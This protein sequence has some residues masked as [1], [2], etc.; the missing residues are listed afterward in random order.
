MTLLLASV[1]P[2]VIF[3]YVIYQKDHEKEPWS[4]LLKCLAGGCFS[5]ILSLAFSLPLSSLSGLFP[6][7]LLGSFQLSFL[8]AAIPEEVAKFIIL[9]GLVWKSR[10]LN[11]HYDGI[12]YAVF[13]SLGF[14]LIENILYVYQGGMQVALVRAVL[15][16]PGHGLFAVLMGYYFTLARFHEGGKRK[17]FLFKSLSLP[18]LFHGGYNFLLFYM[19]ANSTNG[20]VLILLLVAFAWLVIKLWRRGIYKIKKHLAADAKLLR[21][22]AGEQA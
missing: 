12:I 3:L 1:F 8:G 11:H 19:G 21:Q 10:E 20:I 16:V 14:A 17:E 22:V 2:V 4:L 18:I 13:V 7:D 15:S 9:Y 5:T 6:G